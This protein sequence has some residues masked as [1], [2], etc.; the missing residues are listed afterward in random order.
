M[1][2]IFIRSLSLVGKSSILTLIG[3]FCFI[4]SANAWTNPSTNPPS[5]GGVL[6]YSSN[7]NLG[8]GTSDPGSSKLKA[9]GIIESSS[10][11]FKF[12]DGTVQ[13]TAFGGGGTNLSARTV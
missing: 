3:F 7:A 1:N 2:K 10:G 11:G 9:V 4:L 5:S 6:F 8:I 13:T 12:P